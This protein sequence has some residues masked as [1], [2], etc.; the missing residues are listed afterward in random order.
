MPGSSEESEANI[1]FDAKTRN[2]VFTVVNKEEEPELPKEFK[3]IRFISDTGVRAKWY[4]TVL[5]GHSKIE[6]NGT[7]RWVP[8][9][10]LEK[11]H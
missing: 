1:A 3:E 6:A 9:G 11:L 10:Q 2:A 7:F 8:G 5:N 4:Q